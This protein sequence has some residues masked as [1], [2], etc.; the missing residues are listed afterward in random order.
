MLMIFT[1][2]VKIN[3]SFRIK[4]TLKEIKEHKF[5]YFFLLNVLNIIIVNNNPYFRSKVEKNY[6]KEELEYT[7]CLFQY[8][9]AK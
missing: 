7:A 2:H 8:F 1:K 4:R 6:Q 5:P 9:H 3:L